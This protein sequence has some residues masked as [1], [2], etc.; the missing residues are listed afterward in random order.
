VPRADGHRRH[1]RDEAL[2]LGGVSAGGVAAA[3]DVKP[4]AW[5]DE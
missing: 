1:P 3:L 5:L 2:L 4:G